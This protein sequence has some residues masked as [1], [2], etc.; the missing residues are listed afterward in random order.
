MFA[1]ENQGGSRPSAGFELV[2]HTAD[3]AVHAWGESPERVFEQAALGM[4]SLAYEVSRVRASAR[5][6]VRLEAPAREPLLAAWL[7]EILYVLEGRKFLV[8]SFEVKHVDDRRLDALIT[9]ETLDV[10]R[11]RLR[12]IVKAATLHGLRVERT[13][14][15]WEARVVLDI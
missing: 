5:R 13:D 10:D 1:D 2:D 3:V 15:G 4:V 7:N 6:H 11:H 12:G 9:G 14:E 8:A